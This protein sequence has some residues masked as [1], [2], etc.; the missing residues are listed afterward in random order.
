[1]R[2]IYLLLVLLALS[3]KTRDD[4][5]TPGVAPVTFAAP[6]GAFLT[7]NDAESGPVKLIVE[8]DL[9]IRLSSLPQFRANSKT[10]NAGMIGSSVADTCEA[11]YVADRAVVLAGGDIFRIAASI[12]LAD[13]QRA[14][15]PKVGQ[16]T[17]TG[18]LKVFVGMQCTGSDFARF[19]GKKFAEVAKDP[20]LSRNCKGAKTYGVMNNT[21]TNVSVVSTA[22][23]QES[24]AT[25]QIKELTKGLNGEFCRMTRNDKG[26]SIDDCVI[27]GRTVMPRAVAKGVDF[28]SPQGDSYSL[29]FSGIKAMN[30]TDMWFASGKVNVLLNN[31]KGT[32]T[33]SGGATSPK[34]SMSNGSRLLAGTLAVAAVTDQSTSSLAEIGELPSGP[35]S[36]SFRAADILSAHMLEVLLK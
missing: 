6:T 27:A 23:G 10:T 19:N 25:M 31:W 33:Y 15:P 28:S 3:C 36:Q 9:K 18:S 29:K 34:Y 11:T 32:V 35:I 24:E 21:E 30:E 8:S 13:M 5:T 12:D 7:L 17:Q 20:S 26:F 22:V 2:L 16:G 14:C 1:M 4:D